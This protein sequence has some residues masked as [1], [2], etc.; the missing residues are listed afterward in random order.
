MILAPSDGRALQ[1]AG[2]GTTVSSTFLTLKVDAVTDVASVP[3]GLEATT[4]PFQVGPG[5]KTLVSAW[6]AGTR[7]GS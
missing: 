7:R 3:N 2:I 6:K 4:I 5:G 1:L